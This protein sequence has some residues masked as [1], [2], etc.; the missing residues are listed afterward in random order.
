VTESLTGT[1]DVVDG[2]LTAYN[3]TVDTSN[4]TIPGPE[5]LITNFN[6]ATTPGGHIWN[7]SQDGQSW[8]FF[9]LF[10][11]NELQ[12][13]VGG[14]ALGN[15]LLD[16][17]TDYDIYYSWENKFTDLTGTAVDPP[18][19]TPLPPALPL[20]AAGLLALLTLRRTQWLVGN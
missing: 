12:F 19:V 9:F 5:A 16:N 8:S 20:F 3:L 10:E 13:S 1:V 11:Y 2:V 18:T 4:Y 14:G 6:S 17:W 7:L 15:G